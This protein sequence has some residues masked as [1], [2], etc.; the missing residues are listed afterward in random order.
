MNQFNKI[1]QDIKS[2]KIQGA[3]SIALKGLEALNYK[4]DPKKIISAR[5][6]EPTLINAI[7]FSRTTDLETAKNYLIDSKKR[8]IENGIDLISRNPTIFTYCHSDTIV[9]ILKEAKKQR[10]AFKVYNTETRPLYQGRITALALAKAKI[11]ITHVIDSDCD[12]AILKSNIVLLG[13][14]SIFPNGDVVNKIGSG[15]IAKLAKLNKTPVYIITNSWKYSPKLLTLEKRS[16]KEVWNIKN[17]YIEIQ[18]P[19]FDVINRENIKAI[20]T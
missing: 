16:P 2:L 14:D 15:M 12:G 19:A 7:K 11:K 6:T 4:N 17:K 3:Y 13:A 8:V 18:N 1:Y 20:H 5:P 9:S 10:K